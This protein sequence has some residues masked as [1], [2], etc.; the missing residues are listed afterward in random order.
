MSEKDSRKIL[1]E[2]MIASKIFQRLDLSDDFW[3]QF[4][5][6]NKAIKKQVGLFEIESIDNANVITIS[7]NPKECFEKYRDKTV[8]KKHKGLKKDT[9]GMNFEA[10][11][12]RICSLHEF[13]TNQK[14]KKKELNKNVFK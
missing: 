14:P 11:S 6:Q 7:V 12:Q 10:Y 5:V 1:L 8:S 3:E 4:N 2:V 9:P 13:C